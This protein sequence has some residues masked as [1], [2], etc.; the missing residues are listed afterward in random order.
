MVVLASTPARS[1]ATTITGVAYSGSAADPIIT[2]TGTGFD[3]QP[4]ATGLAFT[5]ATGFDFGT[6]L[7]ILDS[8]QDPHSFS[9]GYD[10]PSQNR[11]DFLGLLIL[12]YSNSQIVLSFGSNYVSQFSQG[13]FYQLSEGDS[14]S[15]F[16]QGASYTSAVAF[17]STSPEPG[18]LMTVLS[19]FAIAALLW[20][21]NRF[22]QTHSVP[23]ALRS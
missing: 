2:I 14:L 22:F 7:H 23:A 21:R 17:D 8:S 5:G 20:I 1:S 10:D 12:S 4:A 6:A 19:A 16:V 11:H 13:G 9:A 18:S 3:P 15:V